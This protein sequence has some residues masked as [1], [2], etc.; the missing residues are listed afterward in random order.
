M[1]I[2]NTAKHDLKIVRKIA[3]KVREAER[4]ALRLSEKSERLKREGY[5]RS[6]LVLFW[7][8]ETKL[9]NSYRP[10]RQ[11]TE[12]TAKIRASILEILL[13]RGIFHIDDLDEATPRKTAADVVKTIVD[14]GIIVK[15][16]QKQGKS[17]QKSNIYRLVDREAAERLKQSA[18]LAIFAELGIRRGWITREEVK[19]FYDQWFEKPFQND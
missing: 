15:A 5:L 14:R 10:R 1:E 11:V 19:E 9:P 18:E 3:L 6:K 12:Q 17:G 16:G 7:K 2:A 4:H 8:P 13:S